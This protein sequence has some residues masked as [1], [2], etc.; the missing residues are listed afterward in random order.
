MESKDGNTAEDGF[1]LVIS[2]LSQLKEDED[3]SEK[4]SPSQTKR[5]TCIDQASD[6]SM[7]GPSGYN[8]K[9]TPKKI[10]SL[11]ET[12]PFGTPKKIDERSNIYQTPTKD[13]SADSCHAHKRHRRKV[14]M[15]KRLLSDQE[16]VGD[17]DGIQKRC[18][19]VQNNEE[20]Q[21]AEMD[22]DWGDIDEALELKAGK[23]KMNAKNV[24]TVIRQV[25]TNPKVL[26]L[27]KDVL[28]LET[29]DSPKKSS[30]SN[31]DEMEYEPKMTRAKV[32]DFLERISV[33]SPSKKPPSGP[34][35]LDVDFAEEEEDDEYD[36]AKDECHESD[37]DETESMVSSRLSDFGSPCPLTPS[38]P[39][40]VLEH[41]SAG[42]STRFTNENVSAQVFTP[43][44]QV[45]NTEINLN[46]SGQGNIDSINTIALRTRSKLPLHST[47]ITDIEN[48]FVAPDITPDMYYTNDDADW[49][50]FLSTLYK[51]PDDAGTDD[52]GEANDPEFDYIAEAA[53]EEEDVDEVLF[54]KPTKI[55]KKEVNALM[56][57]LNELFQDEMLPYQAMSSLSDQYSV[58]GQQGPNPKNDQD[59]VF[60]A[61]FVP[62]SPAH[63][64]KQQPQVD[65]LDIDSQPWQ[66]YEAQK[67]N[68]VQ[69]TVI[70]QVDFIFTNFQ[71]ELIKDQ[72][73]KHVQLLAQ[74]FIIFRSQAE[75]SEMME[76]LL[77]E[78][79]Y[80][81]EKSCA[82]EK[83][84]FHACNLEPALAFIRNPLVREM[85]EATNPLMSTKRVHFQVTIAQ[86][87]AMYESSAFV[88]PH[89]LPTFKNIK[90]TQKQEP[91]LQSEDNLIAI[92]LEQFRDC[93]GVGVS[94]LIQKHLVYRKDVRK[95][96]YRIDWL[97]KCKQR[98][99]VVKFVYKN[100]RLPDDFPQSVV[101]DFLPLAPRDQS[102]SLLP[103]WCNVLRKSE[104]THPKPKGIKSSELIEAETPPQSKS[105][106][107]SYAMVECQTRVFPN[108]EHSFAGELTPSSSA[109][110]AT[111]TPQNDKVPLLHSEAFP[112]SSS[113][114]VSS[115]FPEASADE[116]YPLSS[117]TL[118]NIPA[119]PRELNCQKGQIIVFPQ[120]VSSSIPLTGIFYPFENT[121]NSQNTSGD[122]HPYHR[123]QVSQSALHL[124]KQNSL[125]KH[126]PQIQISTHHNYKPRVGSNPKQAAPSQNSIKTENSSCDL[127]AQTL[128]SCGIGED[129]SNLSPIKSDV[130]FTASPISKEYRKINSTVRNLRGA[131]DAA[132]DIQALECHENYS[133][134]RKTSASKIYENPVLKKGLKQEILHKTSA[135]KEKLKIKL[136]PSQSITV[137][138][139]KNC[140]G[141]PANTK[142]Q[143]NGYKATY[144]SVQTKALPGND[145]SSTLYVSDLSL[146]RNEHSSKKNF[147]NSTFRS[148][149]GMT[150]TPLHPKNDSPIEANSKDEDQIYETD[151]EIPTIPE[152]KERS[153]CLTNSSAPSSQLA[154]NSPVEQSDF[155][156]ASGTP[157]A[158]LL[159]KS[160][161]PM[162]ANTAHE[163]LNERLSFLTNSSALSSQI[164]RVNFVEESASGPPNAVLLPKI[165]SPMEANAA[166]E[167]KTC[168]TDNGVPITLETDKGVPITL[169]TDN[170][171]VTLE[172]D[173]DVQI[174]P[175]RS[176][177]TNCSTSSNA[178]DLRKNDAPLGFTSASGTA[179]SLLAPK[180]EKPVKEKV[181]DEKQNHDTDDDVLIITEK[182]GVAAD[183][184]TNSNALGSKLNSVELSVFTSASG[185]D[186]SLLVPKGDG[187]EEENAKY[188]QQIHKTDVFTISKVS[189]ESDHLTCSENLA[190][191]S[192]EANHKNSKEDCS[193]C[194]TVTD[195]EETNITTMP[196]E[197][198]SS[199]KNNLGTKEK[200]IFTSSGE[201]IDI[202]EK[203]DKS[204]DNHSKKTSLLEVE[205]KRNNLEAS[206]FET[207]TFEDYV[208]S[209]DVM[210][211]EPE[212]DQEELD[213]I[214]ASIIT[215][216]CDIQGKRKNEEDFRSDPIP[217]DMIVDGCEA[218]VSEEK[219]YQEE[220]I[221]DY[222]QRVR[223]LLENSFQRFEKLLSLLRNINIDHNNPVELFVDFAMMLHDHMDLVEDFAGVLLSFQAVLCKCYISSH[224]YQ[225]LQKFLSELQTNFSDSITPYQRTL[226]T[227]NKWLSLSKETEFDD[228]FLKDQ[229]VD[230]FQT[231]PSLLDKC[232]HYFLSKPTVTCDNQAKGTAQEVGTDRFNKLSSRNLKDCLR[233]EDKYQEAHEEQLQKDGTH[234]L[235]HSEVCQDEPL[236]PKLA[237]CYSESQPVQISEPSGVNQIYEKTRLQAASNS[238]TKVKEYQ[239][240]ESKNG[241]ELQSDEVVE[242]RKSRKKRKLKLKLAAAKD[243]EVS[244]N[245]KSL[246]IE[247][248][249][250][251]VKSVFPNTH[252]EVNKV[253]VSTSSGLT[254]H[255]LTVTPATSMMSSLLPSMSCASD[256]LG[257]PH[258]S[259]SVS[260]RVPLTA[261]EP[262]NTAEKKI[263]PTQVT[264]TN[265]RTSEN[266]NLLH[267]PQFSSQSYSNSSVSNST[268]DTTNASSIRLIKGECSGM[269]KDSHG[270]NH[271]YTGTT[272]ANPTLQ[273]CRI[274]PRLKGSAHHNAPQ[275]SGFAQSNIIPAQPVL[276]NTC[277]AT[278][279]SNFCLPVLVYVQPQKFASIQTTSK[280]NSLEI[281]PK[282]LDKD[283]HTKGTNET[284]SSQRKTLR[285]S[286]KKTKKQK[287]KTVK[288]N[289]T[290]LDNL[291]TSPMTAETP[292]K[293]SKINT[294]TSA[295]L[296]K[297][298]KLC[299]ATKEKDDGLVFPE[300]IR[301]DTTCSGNMHKSSK[302]GVNNIKLDGT[303]KV[304]PFPEKDN[305]ELSKSIYDPQHIQFE[306]PNTSF[307][308]VQK[309]ACSVTENN[310][311]NGKSHTMSFA[312]NDMKQPSLNPDYNTKSLNPDVNS[313]ENISNLSP[314]KVSVRN[315]S[316][317]IQTYLD[318]MSL[319]PVEESMDPQFL[320]HIAHL[321][322]SPNK[323]ITDSVSKFDLVAFIESSQFACKDLATSNDFSR[324]A[325]QFFNRNPSSSTGPLGFSQA[326]KEQGLGTPISEASDGLGNKVT[327]EEV[328]KE[329][330]T[331]SVK[332]IDHPI[333]PEAGELTYNRCE[334]KE[335]SDE[336]KSIEQIQSKELEM[337]D[338]DN[339]PENQVVYPPEDLSQ[340]VWTEEWDEQILCAVVENEGVTESVIEKLQL[341][342]PIKSITELTSRANELLEIMQKDLEN[343]ADQEER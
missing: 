124:D 101:T 233:T 211:E 140:D 267:L 51:Q 27:F 46:A 31:A 284:K 221:S 261:K 330:H 172:T 310:T 131:F 120:T 52:D 81:R 54:N 224:K 37:E 246:L 168:E 91:F 148:G 237:M 36:P 216:R 317:V 139:L 42:L 219:K 191:E 133:T 71:L 10:Q 242:K 163:Q 126:P 4:C 218:K 308:H 212:V 58:I 76:Y 161:S 153:S 240:E 26:N 289:L 334:E 297:S 296:S 264:V 322:T 106:P 265:P 129:M 182:N 145:C 277:R 209:P 185:T 259:M 134:E 241:G 105:G 340:S 28:E 16:D 100:K 121:A 118:I 200:Q 83:S 60:K 295:L 23:V 122:Q 20:T 222:Y 97:V 151:N 180:T 324:A 45:L 305:G 223:N 171:P 85:G 245:K 320:Q 263:E 328:M 64:S 281:K 32:K 70:Q 132:E 239:S 96:K 50:Q 63:H 262:Q 135:F 198:F 213:E 279:S 9:D 55:S 313:S 179:N 178:L 258:K 30:Q 325:S 181:K 142:I 25:L 24:K 190:S 235:A 343:E 22:G 257:L 255:S 108:T 229:L 332:T 249:L 225:K 307:S 7:P 269:N 59:G 174:I 156:S 189:Q 154:Q 68:Q 67:N 38:T 6:I 230:L 176:D 44:S 138:S 15:R 136:S 318:S 116:P 66:S 291:C 49:N 79:D 253:V 41:K 152:L 309:D 266:S 150:K 252:Y 311:C 143:S 250:P 251:S 231:I 341:Q 114:R 88:Y 17:G 43:H 254:S 109:L 74:S 175:E 217:V 19:V 304:T 33:A 321:L 247:D 89:L 40:Q 149:R 202:P 272:K 271:I 39:R 232:C 167:Q 302:A 13:R 226:A 301:K 290:N 306:T 244:D 147:Q 94:Q 84:L 206:V 77:N 319:G 56:D 214:L 192:T 47:S 276:T 336:I 274:L 293:T 196:C 48:A 173:N 144:S 8:P 160:E 123:G 238:L 312:N 227:L 316:K 188:K 285:S 14:A 186:K 314:I 164:T 199:H 159:P 11:P 292:Q 303:D 1:A 53:L 338:S 194:I 287:T 72:M 327:S 273:A 65:F 86:K 228:N 12:S 99:N 333:V 215:I 110:P 195:N 5:D 21:D 270:T 87:R 103:L 111:S 155:T 29:E 339:V 335:S 208:P 69:E 220:Y 3:L 256:L 137:L 165:D 280:L 125:S 236:V 329:N 282:S 288:A 337:M 183:F 73:R 201:S 127:L 112:Y 90:V 98:E 315:P 62:K 275:F 210:D 170:V 323:H 117:Q 61:P 119:L 243:L 207:D 260:Q 177:V 166:D 146:Q 95:I 197:V 115:I 268:I 157:N 283:V 299:G 35:I 204:H 128:I 34:S 113:Q 187:P 326:F 93:T 2:N 78:L 298:T 300:E 104:Y 141:F 342:I 203:I 248:H 80:L 331:I 18:K 234:T 107:E 162:E 184:S 278:Y 294:V 158:V 102:N 75:C 92:G 205:S 130:P 57:E 169:E 82:G 286:V 193:K